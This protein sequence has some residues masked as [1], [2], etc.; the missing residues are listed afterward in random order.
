[1][2]ARD[3]EGTHGYEPGRPRTPP[4]PSVPPPHHAPPSAVPPPLPPTRP[5]PVPRPAVP[6]PPV[7]APPASALEVWLRTP[8]EHDAPGIYAF[9]HV[10]RTAPDPD[11]LPARRLLGGAVLALLVGLFVWSLFRNYFDFWIWPVIWFTPDHWRSGAGGDTNAFNIA[12]RTWATLCT[13]L[14]ALV[15]ARFGNWAEV[16]RR[17]ARPALRKLWDGPEPGAAPEDRPD[18]VQWPELR[19]ARQDALADRLATEVRTGRMNDVDYAR[20]KR[21]WSVVQA[22]PGRLDAFADA[23]L[24]HGAEACA[25][26]SGARDLPHRG[27]RHDLFAGQVRIGRGADDDRNPYQHRGSGIGLDATLLG[28]GLLVVGPPGSGKTRHV[29]RPVVESLC[30][31]ALAGQA[32][33]VA[34][35]AG[36]AD[37]GPA[38]SFDVVISLADPASRYD[39]DL[40][41]GGTDPD[42]AAG[43]LAE[44]LLDPDTGE[45]GDQRRAATALSQLLGPFAAAH[46]RFPSVTELR[47]LLDGVPHAHAALRDALDAAGAMAMARELEARMRQAGLPGHIGPRLADR[48]ALL[49]RPAFAGFF[50]VTGHSR[51]F[52]MYALEHP[53][54]VRIDLPERGHAEASRILARLVVAQFTAAVTARRDRSL[55]ACL[56]MDDAAHTITAD[57]VRGLSRLRSANAGALLA[58]R[59]LDDAPEHLRTALLGAVG[60]RMALA[61]ITTWDGR[62]FAEAWGTTWVETRDVTRTPDQSGGVLRRAGRGVRKLFT[63]EAV[64]TES[65]TVRK[66]ER[67][68]WSASDLAHGVPAGHAVLSLT[69]TGGEHAPPILLDLRA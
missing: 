22:Q 17:W 28:T 57:A 3:H 7:K 31:Q 52:S 42:A 65:V 45:E 36:G 61:G 10:P 4:S 66:V 48:V 29:V 49:D 5:A 32:A 8:R 64:T 24:R 37:L 41:G 68:R 11:R 1:M 23:V 50:D 34:V 20:I 9:G 44:A 69:T 33:V 56:V 27:A 21:A 60:C 53:L 18:P 40:Y 15:F 47:E 19:E 46:R 26:P 6:P 2:D 25:H 55:F 43:A 51:P 63:G 58:L 12:T 59:T 30:L 38:G 39:L 35:G 62:R 54:R 16:W 67:E 14:L 13:V